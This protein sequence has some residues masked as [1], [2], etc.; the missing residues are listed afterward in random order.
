MATTTTG[1]TNTIVEATKSAT[2]TGWRKAAP[3]IKLL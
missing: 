1:S 3:P 2:T